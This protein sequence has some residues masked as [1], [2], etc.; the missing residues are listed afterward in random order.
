MSETR[1]SAAEA[2]AGRRLLL[3][4]GTGFLGKVFASLLLDR[5]PEMGHLYLLVRSAGDAR[6]RFREEILPSP[7]FDPLRRRYGGRLER[8]LEDKLTVVEGDVGEPLLGLA[9]DVAARVAAECDVVVNAA[10]HV[11]FNAPLDAALRANVSGPQH[12]LAF[13]RLLRRPAL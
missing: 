1:L 11:V 5:F 3:C 10:G 4:G 8:H 12:A 6:R 13:A 9:E 7:A 2:L